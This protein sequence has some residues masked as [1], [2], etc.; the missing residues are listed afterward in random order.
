MNSVSLK[1]VALWWLKFEKQMTHICTEFGT[2]SAD[3]YG[4]CKTRTIEIET[5][6]DKYDLMHD[7]DKRK[8]R[9]YASHKSEDAYFLGRH[10]PNYFFF[11]V[12]QKLAE[13]AS[14]LCDEKGPKYGVL[15]YDPLEEYWQRKF[16]VVRRSRRIHSVPP[17][18]EVFNRMAARM[19]NEIIAAHMWKSMITSSRDWVA[20]TLEERLKN[21]TTD[22]SEEDENDGMGNGAL[23]PGIRVVGNGPT[24][25]DDTGTTNL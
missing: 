23:V 18:E 3:A 5:K 21:K 1:E 13:Q 12:P 25:I 11:L 22:K 10:I 19:S 20:D 15:V 24:D 9:I 17:H 2:Y 6:I 7:F 14:L 4:A 16:T 8:H